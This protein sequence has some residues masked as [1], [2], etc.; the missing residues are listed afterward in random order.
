MR[1]LY[2]DITLAKMRAAA[3]FSKARLRTDLTARTF[4]IEVWNKTSSSWGIESGTQNLS[5]GINYGY[6][7]LSSPPPNT[8]GS[9][10]QAPACQTDA[11]TAANTTGDVSNT[12]CIVFSSRGIPVNETGVPIAADAIYINDGTAVQGVTVAASGLIR[13]WRSPIAS[14]SWKTR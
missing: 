10:N 3:S 14:A 9:I 7:S 5:T 8:Q 13:A 4:Q 6:S 12:A 1:S 2:G 11:E